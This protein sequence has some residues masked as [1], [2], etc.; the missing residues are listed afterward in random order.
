M[1]QTGKYGN[2]Q[3]P[4][5]NGRKL[6]KTDRVAEAE[7]AIGD[8]FPAT[9]VWMKAKPTTLVRFHLSKPITPHQVAL[10]SYRGIS[11]M[12]EATVNDRYQYICEAGKPTMD[13]ETL[14]MNMASISEQQGAP[15]QWEKNMI[16]EKHWLN[17]WGGK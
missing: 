13:I 12:N 10:L 4:P 11:I 9:L 2:K 14:V 1:K 6:A 15:T 17:R 7:K 5:W 8:I 3:Q 16:A